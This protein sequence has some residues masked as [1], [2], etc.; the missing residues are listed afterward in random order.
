[1]NRKFNA[2]GSLSETASSLWDFALAAYA[3]PIIQ[4]HCLYLQDHHQMDV[5]MLLAAGFCGQQGQRWTV[6]LCNELIALVAPIRENY[7]LPLRV[8]RRQAAG[9]SGLYEALKAAE[10]EAERIELTAL[11]G[12]IATIASADG[13]HREYVENNI[14]TYAALH[15]DLARGELLAK[16][17]DLAVKIAEMR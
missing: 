16:L 3:A 4:R 11:A 13:H 12:R 5:N 1:M 17:G 10:L 7:V 14:L 2:D 15:A 6:A 9:S 8:L